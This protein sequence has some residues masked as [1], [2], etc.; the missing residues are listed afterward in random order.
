MQTDGPSARRETRV[1]ASSTPA[2]ACSRVRAWWRRRLVAG[3]VWV[4]PVLVLACLTL[5]HLDQGDWRGDQAW[6]AAIGV[7]A[8]RTGELWTLWAWDG[9]RYFNKPPLV[10]WIHGFVLDRVYVTLAM[11]RLP[12]VAAAALCAI[13]A[14][15]VARELSGR[16]AGL[17]AGAA[18]VLTYEFFRRTREV[19]LDM[20]QTAFL[21]LA[22]WL[23]ARGVRTGR[24]RWVIACGLPVGLALM[25]KPLVGLLAIPILAAWAIFPGGTLVPPSRARVL[26]SFAGAIAVAMLIA[27]PWHLSMWQIH[28]NDFL[29][30]YFGA[31]IA[32]RAA[33][34]LDPTGASVKPWWFYLYRLGAHGWPWT[35]FAALAIV[36]LWRA[37]SPGRH[38]PLIRL[39]LVWTVAWMVLLSLFA[40]KRDRY[41]LPVHAG[42]AWMS[43][44]WLVRWGWAWLRPVERAMVRKGPAVLVIGAIVFA[45]LPVRV[46]R[47]IAP[48]W[49]ALRAWLRN[50]P[51]VDPADPQAEGPV[52]FMGGLE[53][54]DA[55]RI[56]VWENWWA[57]QPPGLEG[58]EPGGRVREPRIGDFVLYERNQGLAPGPGE[59]VVLERDDVTVSRIDEFPWRPV[60]WMRSPD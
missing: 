57:A 45:A 28:G 27:A 29:A 2:R 56:Y 13:G 53:A 44:A 26:A 47:P 33:G 32:S 42:V 10:F 25:T 18:L 37:K 20:W 7:Q 24:A 41:M 5:P 22:A 52:L 46:Q 3:R 36:S 4:L 40:E 31:E 23:V 1:R 58:A 21:L 17:L 35:L 49:A 14:V 48:E 60:W 59:S 30:Q 51:L 15:G 55:A 54:G 39:G 11:A 9:M 8:W 16:R 38:E 6:Y 19:S 50:A 12:T 34:E 43:A